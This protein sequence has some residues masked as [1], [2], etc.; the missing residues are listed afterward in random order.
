MGV[1]CYHLTGWLYGLNLPSL[2][3]YTVDM[4]FLLSGF[5]MTWVYE[6]RSTETF[7]ARQFYVARFA[8][9]APLWWAAI[10]I[11]VLSGEGPFPGW[12]GILENLTFLNAL[13]VTP[14]IATGGWSI[15]IEVL[16]YLLFPAML[17]LLRLPF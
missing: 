1:M 15:K 4:F 8:R 16:F 17:T 12:G 10:I 3:S 6:S 2:G 7:P 14:D 5:A 13:S 11:T 9:L